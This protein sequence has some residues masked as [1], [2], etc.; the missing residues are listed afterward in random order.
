[1]ETFTKT[2]VLLLFTSV[3]TALFTAVVL[4]SKS[5]PK[6]NPKQ[7]ESQIQSI[8]KRL[9]D[10]P[11]N[12][13]FFYG[14]S[15]IRKWVKL[16]ENF[17]PLPVFNAG[18]GG[19]IL[20]D[21]TF[22]APRLLGNITPKAIVIYAGDNDL[23]SSRLNLSPEDT[24]DNFILLVKKINDLIHSGSS[25][26]IYFISVKPSPS[27]KVAWKKM[28]K[29]NFLIK[30]WADKIDNVFYID[31]ASEMLNGDGTFRDELFIPD[32]LHMNQKGYD[33]WTKIIQEAFKFTLEKQ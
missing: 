27:R 26:K 11:Q 30:S 20:S 18:F 19:S 12:G 14:S 3:C 32:G 10:F 2:K 8:E 7:W 22:F 5:L 25:V 9:K 24:L 17:K 29:A 4:Y 33:L 13:V 28:E 6:H 23:F 16:K 15:S 1:M 21:L 31:T